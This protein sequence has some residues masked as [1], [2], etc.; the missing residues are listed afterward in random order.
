MFFSLIFALSKTRQ[1]SENNES[2]TKKLSE[3][4]KSLKVIFKY[5][6]SFITDFCS[7]RFVHRDRYLEQH[8]TEKID[9]E[10]NNIE[11][12]IGY[13]SQKCIHPVHGA[14]FW[15]VI[16]ALQS[17]IN[18]FYPPPPPQ[19]SSPFSML[20]NEDLPCPAADALGIY[21]Y[22]GKERDS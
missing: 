20:I 4:L 12:M 6:D 17:D 2:E 10:V 22:G 13:E 9:T 14:A 8:Q 15:G 19:S 11:D 1:E 5:L 18:L 21:F 7:G 3:K 16:R